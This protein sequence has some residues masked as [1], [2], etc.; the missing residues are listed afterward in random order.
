MTT[1]NE[2]AVIEH[3]SQ[4]DRALIAADP[5]LTQTDRHRGMLAA[6]SR[7]VWPP[8][9]RLP[10]AET[11]FSIQ[12]ELDNALASR[13]S[14]PYAAK[15]AFTLAACYPSKSKSSDEIATYLAV[16]AEELQRFPSDICRDAV[17]E[18][19]RT[20]KFLP[21]IAEAVA[22]CESRHEH[23]KALLRGCTRLIDW[24]KAE[25]QEAERLARWRQE[26]NAEDCRRAASNVVDEPR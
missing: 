7:G 18:L 16:L 6:A 17:L 20:S 15:C 12:A 2:I 23:R 9:G 24:R 1:G 5:A 14:G 21:S 26:W 22:A 8:P 3:G 19:R 10:M 11:L 13:A 4:D 25:D